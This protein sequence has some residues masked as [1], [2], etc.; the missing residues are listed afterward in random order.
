MHILVAHDDRGFLASLATTLRSVGHK[1]TA[2]D[3]AMSAWD[4]LNRNSI[5]LLVTRLQFPYPQPDGVALALKARS[6]EHDLR[7]LFI[8]AAE[9][10]SHAGGLGTYLTSPVSV[11]QVMDAVA[12]APTN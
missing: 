2:C 3:N 11:A 12:K 5:N 8:E 1:V 7:V 6:I 10:R 4:D 9:F